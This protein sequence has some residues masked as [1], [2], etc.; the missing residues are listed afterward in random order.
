MEVNWTILGYIAVSVTILFI[1]AVLDRFFERKPKISYY[2]GHSSSFQLEAP[3]RSQVNTHSVVVVNNGKKTAKQVR[4]VHDIVPGN[5]NVYPQRQHE[6]SNLPDGG[7]EIIL[8]TLVPS[9]PVTISYLYFP[10]ITWH[11]FNTIVR[12]DDGLGKAIPVIPTRQFPKWKLR[13]LSFFTLLGLIAFIYFVYE[14][15]SRIV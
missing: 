14:L 3:Q 8:P 7:A 12:H 5:Y 13:I 2:L 9:D 10:P 15:I 4:I 1:G 11:Q 6:L